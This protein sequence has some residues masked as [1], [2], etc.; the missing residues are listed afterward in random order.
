MTTTLNNSYLVK[1]GVKIAQNSVHMVCTR[2]HR[3]ILS[4]KRGPT[5]QL[6]TILLVASQPTNQPTFAVHQ[7][8]RKLNISNKI[9]T[10]TG[11]NP[12]E[13][14]FELQN[15]SNIY[16]CPFIQE[17]KYLFGKSFRPNIDFNGGVFASFF[18]KYFLG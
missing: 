16:Q 15:F 3:R 9:E 7:F 4:L 10:H 12:S 11:A 5:K 18:W 1:G 17:C 2:P 8:T 13:S 14:Q 6:A